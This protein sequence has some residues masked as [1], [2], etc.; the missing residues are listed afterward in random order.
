MNLQIS[1]IGIAISLVIYAMA[2]FALRPAFRALGHRK[3]LRHLR[4]PFGALLLIVPW[5]DEFWISWKFSEVCK[6]AGVHIYQP[7]RAEG[8]YDE[9][10]PSGYEY[11]KRIG[12][13][14]MEHPS[15]DSRGLIDHIER[16]G[17]KLVVTTLSSPSARYRHRIS[18][19]NERIAYHIFKLEYVV[20]DGETSKIVAR[21]TTYK[22]TSGW[23]EELWVRYLGTGVSMCPDPVRGP[24]QPQFPESAI[25]P[26]KGGS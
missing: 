8:F 19:N 21:N 18:S 11:I 26:I 4:W 23:I 10:M 6:N 22:R 2:F 9:T 15:Q 20:L 7:I 17:D 3:L 16:I 25:V 1:P 24:H 14:F 12:Y 5:M 13:K